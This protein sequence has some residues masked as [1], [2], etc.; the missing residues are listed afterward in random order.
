MAELKDWIEEQELGLISEKGISN[1]EAVKMLEYS[2][3]NR[4]IS[5][6]QSKLHTVAE[7]VADAFKMPLYRDLVK[8]CEQTQIHIDNKG[9]GDFK[10]IAIEQWQGKTKAKQSI[11]K[12]MV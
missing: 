1:G 10:Q 7:F 3:T 6:E 11:F 8:Y 5:V 4:D 12:A 9:R 2:P